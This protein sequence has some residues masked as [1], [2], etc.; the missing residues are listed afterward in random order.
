MSFVDR[1]ISDDEESKRKQDFDN[2]DKFK[3]TLFD[4]IDSRMR[5]ALFLQEVKDRWNA[6]ITGPL[7]YW[8]QGGPDYLL[9]ED[10][11]P[12]A[13]YSAQHLFLIRNILVLRNGF[14]TFTY[15]K[16]NYEQTAFTFVQIPQKYAFN[17]TMERNRMK[18]SVLVPYAYSIK[19]ETYDNIESSFLLKQYDFKT[20]ELDVMGAVYSQ[21]NRRSFKRDFVTERNRDMLV[22][23]LLAVAHT[24]FLYKHHNGR[25]VTTV[26]KEISNRVFLIAREKI[27]ALDTTDITVDFKVARYTLG[28]SLQTAT[29]CYYEVSFEFDITGYDKLTEEKYESLQRRYEEEQQGID[30]TGY[31]TAMMMK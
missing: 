20:M 22:K 5:R 30:D 7:R 10:G 3:V 2:N 17:E 1:A 15:P 18:I 31:E 12:N 13:G 11:R 24:P 28:I 16:T 29:I 8:K 26:D 27:E 9:P 4:K 19:D 21:R 23:K 14:N 6:V 25:N